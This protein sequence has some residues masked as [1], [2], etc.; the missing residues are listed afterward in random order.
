MCVCVD[1]NMTH[2]SLT[3]RHDHHGNYQNDLQQAK[4][5]ILV[6]VHLH[7]NYVNSTITKTAAETIR[8]TRHSAITNNAPTAK[9]AI[10]RDFICKSFSI[11]VLAKTKIKKGGKRQQHHRKTFNNSSKKTKQKHFSFI[12]K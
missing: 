3:I 5:I 2:N 4:P 9:A 11:Y 10:V 1:R 8:S 12:C 7:D 6:H